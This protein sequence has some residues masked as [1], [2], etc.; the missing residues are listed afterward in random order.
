MVRQTGFFKRDMPTSQGEEKTLKSNLL[1]SALNCLDD[2]KKNL[3]FPE[4]TSIRMAYLHYLLLLNGQYPEYDTKLHQMKFQ[5]RNFEECG[6]YFYFH[7]S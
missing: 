7:Y 4:A 6:I 1:N 3:T 2:I 5:S